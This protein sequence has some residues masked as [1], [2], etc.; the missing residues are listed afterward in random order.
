MDRFIFFSKIAGYWTGKFWVA[1][2]AQAK[3]YV[4]ERKVV[5][6]FKRL[7]AHQNDVWVTTEYQQ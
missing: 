2:K 5:S 1:D 6:T 3:K 4:N 7:V